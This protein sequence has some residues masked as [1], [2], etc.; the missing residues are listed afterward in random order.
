MVQTHL[1]AMAEERA[2]YKQIIKDMIALMIRELSEENQKNME[3]E[4]LKFI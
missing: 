2:M 3:K 4:K 1:Q